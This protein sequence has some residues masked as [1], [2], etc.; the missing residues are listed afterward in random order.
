MIPE[1]HDYLYEH[2]D[3]H[4]MVKGKLESGEFIFGK[5]AGAGIHKEN[6]LKILNLLKSRLVNRDITKEF[7]S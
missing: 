6:Q 4:F 7:T 2:R 5:L 1:L 3:S